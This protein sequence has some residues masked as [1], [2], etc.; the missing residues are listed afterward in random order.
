MDG[1]TCQ[2]SHDA[3][4]G[5]GPLHI[6][7][8]WASEEGLALGQVATQGHRT[9]KSCHSGTYDYII[10]T[11]QGGIPMAIPLPT[12]LASVPD[13]RRETKN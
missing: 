12:A 10:S 1:K 9:M 5:L 7:S 8:A 3:A 6:V 11:T 13:L 2:N 4:A